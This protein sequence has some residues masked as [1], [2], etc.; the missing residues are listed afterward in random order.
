MLGDVALI[1]T[2]AGVLIAWIVSG[3][4]VGRHAARVGLTAVQVLVLAGCAGGLGVPVLTLA[5]A[6]IV[7]TLSVCVSSPRPCMPVGGLE[8]LMY[9]TTLLFVAGNAFVAFVIAG[10][11]VGAIAGIVARSTAVRRA[12]SVGRSRA[13]E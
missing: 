1:A 7:L 4:A 10:M 13:I 11:G 9:L 5:V 2:C 3:A 8:S 12:A 6:T